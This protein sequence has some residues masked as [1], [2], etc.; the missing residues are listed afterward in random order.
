MAANEMGPR[1]HRQIGTIWFYL[2]VAVFAGVALFMLV[3]GLVEDDVVESRRAALPA[4][5]A[6]LFAGLGALRGWW[7]DRRAA[8]DLWGGQDDMRRRTNEAERQA[9]EAER[10]AEDREREAREMRE[11]ADHERNARLRAESAR[12]A[13]REWNRELRTQIVRLHNQ[14]G[15]LG[16][17]DDIRALVLHIAVT[18]LEAEKGM[19]FSRGDE[20]RDG[21]LDLICSEG[22]ENPP[23]DSIVAQRF[24]EEV[25]ERD[26]TIRE[27]DDR[28][29]DPERSTPADEEIRNLVAIPIYVEDEFSGVVLCANNESGFEDHDEEV[30]LAMGDHAGAVLENTR[31]HG[32]LRNSYVATVRMLAEALEAKDPFLRGHSEEVSGY[33]A[34]VAERLDL[35]R[36][37]REEVVFG[38]LLHDVG[39]IGISERILLKPA[40]LTPEERS[41]I[42]LHPRI[43]YRLVQQVPSLKPIAHA[44]LHHH[45]R[46]DGGG[47]PGRLTG[48]EIPLEARIICVADS[49]SAMTA[50]RP[51]KGR[52]SLEEACEELE[53]CAGTQ[54]D[55]EIVRIFVEEV[56]KR[57][58]EE[59]G[60]TDELS[61]ALDDPEIAERIDED[62]PLLGYGAFAVTDNLTLLY[63]HRYFHEAAHAEAQRAAVQDEGFAVVL[64]EVSD[65][66]EINRR[67]GYAAGDDA[68]RRVA[69]AVQ[70]AAVRC[71]GTAARYSGRRLALIAPRADEALAERLAAEIGADLGEGLDVTCAV[72]AWQPGEDGED[73][74]ARARLR[75]QP[76]G[77]AP[78][79]V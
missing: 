32:A 79:A 62:E 42:Q 71:G 27:S 72:A 43:G 30:L 39:K 54:F 77:V 15:A 21:K 64:V 26:T 61:A 55:P 19:L 47:Y 48:E 52:M 70:R 33:V 67:D 11:R 9:D 22:F 36:R 46:Y 31:L 18:L 53:R 34:A 3:H 66:S 69:R 7:H 23:E 16:D 65:I 37:R 29:L 25:I 57:P 24:A 63:C 1:G 35:P 13:E 4:L 50:E 75:L 78:P 51:Y 73:V 20:D 44:I 28:Q 74:V 56:R 10:R 68:I 8:A 17:W 59:G 5:V 6:V 40:G 12:R 49:F 38:S 58:P 60:H 76:T 14:H 2:A 45:E 41:V